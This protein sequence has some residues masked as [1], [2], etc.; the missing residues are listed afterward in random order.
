[1]NNTNYKST[2]AAKLNQYNTLAKIYLT[3]EIR[4]AVY[5]QLGLMHKLIHHDSQNIN[6]NEQFCKTFKNFIM[7]ISIMLITYLLYIGLLAYSIF[8]VTQIMNSIQCYFEK[9]RHPEFYDNIEAYW[10]MTLAYIILGFILWS[11]FMI[12]YLASEV[13]GLFLFGL[14]FPIAIYNIVIMKKKYPMRTSNLSY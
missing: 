14:S 10:M 6:V 1:M 9:G 4:K 7:E 12:P 8:G 11:P 5:F 13:Y 2:E 3:S